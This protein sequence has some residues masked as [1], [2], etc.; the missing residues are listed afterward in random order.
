MKS[1]KEYRFKN[2][3][4]EKEFHD[5]FKGLFEADE[6]GLQTLSSIIFGWKN[7]TQTIPNDNLTERET[8]ICLNLIQWLGSP[9]GQSFL[10]ECGFVEKVSVFSKDFDYKGFNEMCE[11]KLRKL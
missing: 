2:N 1:N 10:N 5:K 11:K 3:P 8:D 4:K 9:V 6:M 7:D